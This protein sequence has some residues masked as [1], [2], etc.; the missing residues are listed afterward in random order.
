MEIQIRNAKKEDYKAVE[1]MMEQVQQMHIRW[2]PDL[3]Q[4]NETVLS[5]EMYEQAV[6]DQTAFV[7]E[8]DGHVAGIVLIMYR[9]IENPVQV[10]RNIIFV[11]SM[12]VDE[13]YRGKG[14][15]HAFFD[16]LKEL[17]EQRGYDGIELQ[18]NAKNEAAYK[19]YADYGFTNKSINME[20]L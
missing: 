2:R 10:T 8:C 1:V 14:I 12:A 4:F 15:G 16:F 20:L 5:Y 18:V 13:A 3:Y 7:A 19:M 9:H 6:A 17:K 11:D